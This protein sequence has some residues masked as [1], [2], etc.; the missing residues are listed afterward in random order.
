MAERLPLFRRI[1]P[2]LLL[3]PLA[4][5]IAEFLLG[6]FSIRMLAL[7]IV[8]APMYGGGA[9]LIREVTRRTNRAW[10][11]MLLLA[12]AYAL[13]EEAY[14]T[15]SLFNP[16]YA[17]ARLLDYGYIPALGT[18]LNW[19]VFVLSIHV[20]WSV[21]T[22]I[23]IAEGIAGERRTEPWLKTP[24]MVITVLLFLLGCA[25]TTNFSLHASPF[26]ASA[27]QLIG[28]GVLVVIVIAAAFAFKPRAHVEAAAV[29]PA[30]WIVFVVTFVLAAA[31]IMIES[32][33]RGHRLLPAI[34]LSGQLACELIALVV[35][36]R[37]SQ[38]RD[39]GSLQYLAIAA[40]TTLTYALFGFYAFLQGHTHL[41]APTGAVDMAGQIVLTLLILALIGWGA[42]RSQR[43][44][45]LRGVLA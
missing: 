41:G 5:L 13:L 12:T 14:T 24:G 42:R 22:P 2:A 44:A 37:W 19:T 28:A 36:A 38:R 33:G 16:D 6:D 27:A 3:I 20:V 34:G 26:R 21:A 7:V 15:Q 9:L 35:I 39:W 1:G 23:L 8:L 4:P 17:G 11:T 43:A 29:A 40:G 32:M 18:S 25:A 30:G 10:P 45:G 31:F